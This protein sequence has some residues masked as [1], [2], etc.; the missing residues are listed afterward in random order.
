M[1]TTSERPVTAIDVSE[2]AY[3]VR[4]PILLPEEWEL[5]D[6]RFEEICRLNPLSQFERT[7]DGKLYQLNASRAPVPHIIAAI[8]TA[9]HTWATAYGG[10]VNGQ[11]Q[12]DFPD[13][14]TMIPDCSWVTQQV[15]DRRTD[16]TAL[17]TEAPALVVEVASM[18][19]DMSQQQAKMVE[20]IARGSQL[21]WLVDP[22]NE[23]VYVYRAN[24]ASGASEQ[25]DRPEELSG[26]DICPGLVV[27]MQPLWD[28]EA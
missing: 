19:D 22:W 7:A 6:E 5:T 14:R 1:T 27:P 17:F 16:R 18:H 11:G 24:V 26:E 28:I 4:L 3:G 10:R 20:W 8:T 15:L 12:Y 23:T 21:G 25:L 2:A 9:L 13:S